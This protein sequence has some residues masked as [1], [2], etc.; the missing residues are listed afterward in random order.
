MA[1]LKFKRGSAN[2]SED[3]LQAISLVA[4]RVAYIMDNL[5]ENDA[6]LLA[7]FMDPS[8]DQYV[9]G[10]WSKRD[11]IQEAIEDMIDFHSNNPYWM[12]NIFNFADEMMRGTY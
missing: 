10:G 3:E 2:Y 7:G 11:V 4:Q 9:L 8:L 5:S 6:R 12:D 1:G